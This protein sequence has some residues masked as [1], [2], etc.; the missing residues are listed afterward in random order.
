VVWDGGLA[1][2]RVTS[3]PQYKAQRPPMPDDLEQQIEQIQAY[4][5]AACVPSICHDG[6]EADDL[7]ATLTRQAVADGAWVIVASSDKDFMQLVS[8]RV[9]LLN[10][11]DKSETIWTAEQVSAK[12]G[13]NP[14]QIVD[15]LSLIG[16]SVDN[17]PGVTGVGPKTAAE[18]INEHGSTAEIYRNLP[19]V[20]SER[21]RANLTAA[22]NAVERN[23]NLIRLRDDLPGTDP[24]NRFEVQAVD[25]DRLRELYLR[26]GFKTLLQ[27]LEDQVPSQPN[28][29]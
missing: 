26:W 18:L 7:I 27:E 15:W 5:D 29:F 9:G 4:L 8:P 24:V 23:R 20:T 28:L 14:E 12:T 21:L 11:N 13:V 19:A 1:V 10:P 3:L 17:I 22:Q 16:D 25:C 6:V 2:E